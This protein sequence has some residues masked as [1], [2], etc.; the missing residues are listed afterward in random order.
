MRLGRR[1]GL[2]VSLDEQIAREI[3]QNWCAAGMYLE[4]ARGLGSISKKYHDVLLTFEKAP[5]A[6]PDFRLYRLSLE[7]NSACVRLYSLDERLHGGN[8][9]IRDKAYPAGN[10]KYMH[11]Y[12]RD[13]IAHSEPL[14]GENETWESR[15]DYLR[16]VTFRESFLAVKDAHAEMAVR[17]SKQFS[18]FR[19]LAHWFDQEAPIW[20]RKIS[21]ARL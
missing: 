18:S 21:A 8:S 17:A 4:R 15:K 19:D 20:I 1:K 2:R 16:G 13:A 5:K 6:S 10:R 7:L 9:A 3:K 11:V 14:P 12:L